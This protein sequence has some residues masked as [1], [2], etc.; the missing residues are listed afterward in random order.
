MEGHQGGKPLLATSSYVVLQ[1]PT[2]T[3]PMANSKYAQITR[4]PPPNHSLHSKLF[5]KWVQV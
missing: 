3:T 4:G 2:S 5:T 1:R